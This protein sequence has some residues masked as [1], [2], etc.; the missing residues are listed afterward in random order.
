MI[1]S[2]WAKLVSW[3][4]DYSYELTKKGEEDIYVV[5][6]SVTSVG[7]PYIDVEG[8]AFNVMP[9]QGGVIVQL[10]SYDR[11]T[12]RNNNSTH[13]IPEGADVAEHVGKIVAMELWKA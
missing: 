3:G 1:R 13:I 10:R 2:L 9:A 8:L 6:E 11:K 5:D 12:D 7:R 4:W